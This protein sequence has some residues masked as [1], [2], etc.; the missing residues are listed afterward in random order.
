MFVPAWSYGTR[1]ARFAR[2][3]CNSLCLWHYA[4]LWELVLGSWAKS[5]LVHLSYPS[6][7]PFGTILLH[8]LRAVALEVTVDLALVELVSAKRS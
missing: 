6:S 1:S 2:S 4:S 7:S 5:Y 8:Q 3:C